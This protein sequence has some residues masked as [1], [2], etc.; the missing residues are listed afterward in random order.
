[1]V[2]AKDGSGDFIKVQDAIDAVA[3]NNSE[4]VVIHIKSGVY[5]E[6]LFIN[7][8]FITLI[9]ESSENT[10]LTYDDYA[11]KIMEDGEKM[12]TF[13][14][15]ST[16]VGGDDFSAENITFENSAGS[17]EKVGQALAIYA[18]GD[19]CKF[20][21]CRFLGAQD[22]IFTGPLPPAPIIAGSFKGPREN[23]ARRNSRQYYENCYIKG[24]V[25][26]I[27]GSATVLFNKCE[28][29][30]NDRNKDVNGYLTAASTPQ[31]V[32]YGYV[33]I[34]CKLTSDAK[35]ETYYLGRPWREH[36]NVVFINCFMGEHIK[37]E[38]WH[39]WNKVQYEHLFRYGE[40]NSYGPGAV[41]NKRAAFSKVLSDEEVK[42]Y[43][44]K[45]V[46]SGVD[47]WNPM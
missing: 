14:S 11:D 20:K 13:R 3:E 39:N 5:K 47:G 44:I 28:I 17:G 2:V 23:E 34:D 30:A 1:M 42:Q 41:L 7:K 37:A 12:G 43:S 25:D 33:F 10:I 40:Y 15:Y 6:K 27:F 8:S 36:A 32:K 4:R 46:L 45:N 18:D 22:T 16:F 21:N 19:R 38:G 9:G 31:N 35:R 26:F 29:F 24:D